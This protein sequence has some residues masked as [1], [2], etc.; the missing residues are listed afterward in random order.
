MRGP[1]LPGESAALIRSIPS[2]VTSP[3]T[4]PTFMAR[5]TRKQADILATRLNSMLSRPEEC[6]QLEET[7]GKYVAQIGCIHICAQNG[8]HNIYELD[9]AAGGCRG[10]AYGLTIRECYDWLQAACEGVQLARLA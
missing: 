2:P 1:I 4:L 8:T 10:L 9:N 6:Y 3:L 5:I 7:T